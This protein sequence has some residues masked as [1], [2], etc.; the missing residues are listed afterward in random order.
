MVLCKYLIDINSIAVLNNDT[1]TYYFKKLIK[2][3]VRFKN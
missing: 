1:T 3:Y 2:Y